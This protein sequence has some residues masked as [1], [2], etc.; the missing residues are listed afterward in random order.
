[1]IRLS[2]EIHM[3]THALFLHKQ[4]T[5][6]GQRHTLKIRMRVS[7]TESGLDLH[8]LLIELSITTTQVAA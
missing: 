4:H 5:F 8:C 1:M 2:A 7:R 6:V 3:K